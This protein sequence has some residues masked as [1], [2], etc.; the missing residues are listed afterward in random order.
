MPRR[1]GKT[2][3]K[4][5]E[6]VLK[7]AVVLTEDPLPARQNLWFVVSLV[8]HFVRASASGVQSEDAPGLCS[9]Y[10]GRPGHTKR[11]N[12]A[13]GSQFWIP[14]YVRHPERHSRLRVAHLRAAHF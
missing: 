10:S 9:R 1:R 11:A 7:M 14:K 8:R 3:G 13:R 5:P 2:Q 4:E 12:A 6:S